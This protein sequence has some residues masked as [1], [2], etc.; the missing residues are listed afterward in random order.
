[1]IATASMCGLCASQCCILFLLIPL[2]PWL[3]QDMIMRYGD[4]FR[5]SRWYHPLSASNHMGMQVPWVSLTADTCKTARQWN[6]GATQVASAMLSMLSIPSKLK[7]VL[8]PFWP[9]CVQ[10]S[11]TRCS[12]YILLTLVGIIACLLICCSTCAGC[13]SVYCT[14]RVH[15]TKA[16]R[17]KAKEQANFRGIVSSVL[18]LVGLLLYICGSWG[19]FVI[20]NTNSWYPIPSFSFGVYAGVLFWCFHCCSVSTL[21][22]NNTG[23]F[24]PSKKEEAGDETGFSAAAAMPDF[25]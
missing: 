3:S 18:L 17:K 2:V 24:K 15:K 20:L 8:C 16:L 19:A 5:K 12:A 22:A 4:Y 11:M 13:S 9:E 23:F 6:S 14:W 1:M 25:N 21:Y 10:H 7:T